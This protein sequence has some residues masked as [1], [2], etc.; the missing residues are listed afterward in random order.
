MKYFDIRTLFLLYKH[1]LPYYPKVRDDLNKKSS[2]YLAHICKTTPT[3]TQ[4]IISFIEPPYLIYLFKDYTIQFYQSILFNDIKR[5]NNVFKK[6]VDHELTNKKIQSYYV[7]KQAS[8]DLYQEAP[9]NFIISE[10][11]HLYERI[12]YLLQEYIRD[13]SWENRRKEASRYEELFEVLKNNFYLYY[14]WIDHKDMYNLTS[15]L[16]KINYQLK[17]KSI[18]CKV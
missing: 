2:I 8:I 4:N 15:T 18:I 3:I 7:M 9:A 12:G 13:L 17:H 16:I 14:L 11:I 5:L 1:G 10:A 6:T